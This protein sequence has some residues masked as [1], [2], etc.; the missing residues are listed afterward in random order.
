MTPL[1]ILWITHSISFPPCGIISSILSFIKSIIFTSR[2]L[3]CS[4]SNFCSLVNYI[5]ASVRKV[6]PT[7]ETSC[8]LF[9][10][11][12]NSSS[13][14]FLSF[15]VVHTEISNPQVQRQENLK[16]VFFFIEVWSPKDLFNIFTHKLSLLRKISLIWSLLNLDVI[17][18]FD[19]VGKKAVTSVSI[20]LELAGS[21][22]ISLG[23]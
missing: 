8:L 2:T 17:K 21:I 14:P 20:F 11:L 16:A 22:F 6:V 13:F 4:W 10:S 23:Q 18:H 3:N 9:P 5:S 15:L 19:L 1:R 7:K 12:M